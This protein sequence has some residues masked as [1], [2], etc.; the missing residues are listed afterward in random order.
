MHANNPS[1]DCVSK[2]ITGQ[3]IPV[4]QDLVGN[5]AEVFCLT[6]PSVHD[7]PIIFASEGKFD[8]IYIYPELASNIVLNRI[9]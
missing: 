1:T 6:D 9:S 7:N 8:L 3:A 2:D 4:V 5:L